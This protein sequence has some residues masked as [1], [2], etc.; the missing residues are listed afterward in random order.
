MRARRHTK[1]LICGFN[2]GL[3][4]NGSSWA[5]SYA[6][7]SDSILVELLGVEHLSS[8]EHVV[9]RACQLGR[10]DGKGL[11]L[12]VLLPEPLVQLLRRGVASSPNAHLRWALPILRPECPEILPA[13]SRVGL[14]RRQ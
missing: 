8:A 2:A 5:L 11:T 13:D 3:S 6:A 14:T 4:L 12:A 9:H 10:E 7:A 1:H